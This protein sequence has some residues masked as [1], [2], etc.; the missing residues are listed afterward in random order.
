MS[1]PNRQGI[2]LVIFSEVYEQV[3][4][5]GCVCCS[6]DGRK[7]CWGTASVNG[8]TSELLPYTH[9]HLV[10]LQ[11]IFKSLIG[12]RVLTSHVDEFWSN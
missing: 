7:R 10:P 3:C 9:T 4:V 5:Y 8:W 6:W 2:H 11:D 1:G 12:S